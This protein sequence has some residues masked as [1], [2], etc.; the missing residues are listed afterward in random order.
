MI[1]I[2]DLVSIRI[3]KLRRKLNK[4]TLH[5]SGWTAPEPIKL[6]SFCAFLQII[7][8]PENKTKHSQNSDS[9]T[10]PLIYRHTN[11]EKAKSKSL[12]RKSQRWHCVPREPGLP[13]EQLRS[14][15]FCSPLM[16]KPWDHSPPVLPMAVR[17]ISETTSLSPLQS[18]PMR[19]YTT[20]INTFHV[21]KKAH[22]SATHMSALYI[23]I[24]EIRGT[25]PGLPE[26]ELGAPSTTLKVFL[27]TERRG[28][29]T[30]NLLVCSSL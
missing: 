23:Y 26:A 28:R 9:Q 21:K 30:F 1:K 3:D 12:Y 25:I 17:K 16:Y 10:C 2:P 27:R 24:Y 19:K 7:L 15:N 20:N 5:D 29:E 14:S 13:T 8:N 11:S 4:F 18:R 6:A 22:M